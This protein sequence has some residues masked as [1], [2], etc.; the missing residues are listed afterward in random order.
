MSIR[1]ALTVMCGFMS[2]KRKKSSVLIRYKFQDI[3]LKWSS[4][5]AV[6]IAIGIRI[7]RI[8][9]FPKDS[10]CANDP[11]GIKLC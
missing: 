1:L 5:G 9:F 7:G 8:V 3:D 4:E 11:S 2:I 6:P 10:S